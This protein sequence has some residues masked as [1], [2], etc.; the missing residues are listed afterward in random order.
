MDAVWCYLKEV[1]ILPA[2]EV[3]GNGG[4]SQTS[5]ELC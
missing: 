5:E 4:Q 2:G 3:C 1:D